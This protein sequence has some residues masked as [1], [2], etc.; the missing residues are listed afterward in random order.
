MKWFMFKVL[1]RQLSLFLVVMF[2]CF[3]CV[4]ICT[5][6][7]LSWLWR[8]ICVWFLKIC[9][10]IC[11]IFKIS[12]YLFFW[13]MSMSRGLIFFYLFFLRYVYVVGVYFLC[14]S[15]F[16]RYVYVFRVLHSFFYLSIFSAYACMCLSMSLNICVC[17]WRSMFICVFEDLWDSMSLKYVWIYLCHWMSEVS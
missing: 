10:W 4:S 17:L 1:H 9:L 12:F 8:S 3:H 2:S 5:M 11:L 13:G 6:G 15:I 16:W 14:L 7:M